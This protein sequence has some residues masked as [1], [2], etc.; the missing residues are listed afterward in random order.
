MIG[1]TRRTVWMLALMNG[2]MMPLFGALAVMYA[3][4]GDTVV[5]I[6]W[7]AGAGC[8]LVAAVFNLL[9][10]RNVSE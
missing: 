10:L 4:Q 6:V 9:T 2:A 3:L 5:S 7:A 8:W 1:M